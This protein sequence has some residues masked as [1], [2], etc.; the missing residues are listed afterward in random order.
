MKIKI[1]FEKFGMVLK[2]ERYSCQWPL[3][4]KNHGKPISGYNDIPDS[5]N[6]FF[7][8][9]TFWKVATPKDWLKY[10]KNKGELKKLLDW[11]NVKTEEEY[12]NKLD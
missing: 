7:G 11:H 10:Y 1:E 6:Y 3:N 5:I 4:N 9:F 8:P 12:L 2:I